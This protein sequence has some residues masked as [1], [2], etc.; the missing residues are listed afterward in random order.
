MGLR[1]LFKLLD[2]WKQEY[3]DLTQVDLMKEGTSLVHK[4]ERLDAVPMFD[5]E[6]N[7]GDRFT[8]PVVQLDAVNDLLCENFGFEPDHYKWQWFHL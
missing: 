1:D 8:E 6:A 7:Y 3:S 5:R 4:L 2:S